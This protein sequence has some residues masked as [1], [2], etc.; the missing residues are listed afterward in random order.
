MLRRVVEDYLES[1]KEIQ[2]F[3]PFSSLLLL[4]GYHDIHIIHSSVEFGKD[5]IA[6]KEEDG[7]V[8]Q[9][10]YQLKAGDINLPK[11]REEIQPQLL[12]AIVNNL[13]HPNYDST[14]PKKVFFVTTGTVR[15]PA[16]LAFQEFNAFIGQKFK[17]DPVHSIEKLELVEDFV[18]FGLEPFFVLHNDPTFI[19]DFFDL[20]S[21]I[22]N[23][24]ALD[25]FTIEAYTKRWLNIDFN[26]DINRLQVFLEAYLFS[27]LLYKSKR[28]YESI[29]FIAA[30]VRCLSKNNLYTQHHKVIEEFIS[31]TATI[32]IEDVQALYKGDQTL[33]NPASTTGILAIFKYPKFCLH[34]L[35]ILSLFNLLSE[36]VEPELTSFIKEIIEKERGWERPLSDN[37]AV[38]IALIGLSLIKSSEK[39]IF[40]KLINNV[41]IWFC[42]RHSKI[43][44][45]P[46]GASEEEESEQLLSEFLDGLTHNK[47]RSSFLACVLLDLAYLSDDSVFYESI[48][49]ELRASSVIIERFH[50]LNDSDIYD[51]ENISNSYDSE[52]SKKYTAIYSGGILMDIEN[53]KISI[54]SNVLFFLAF[55]LRD[56]VF[57][58]FIREIM[59]VNPCDA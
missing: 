44:L 32:I 36:K 4:K 39:D 47:M 7:V 57:P 12:E 11:F 1:I 34:A 14:L 22:R 29:L 49:N 8:V 46:L 20:Y 40:K 9:Y 33:A 26:N 6:K 13:A 59:T 3:L 15:P 27:S 5:I 28:Y 2:F 54:R 17:L 53:S 52:Y 55:L 51:Y 18:K 41:T 50:I 30:L 56:R 10:V 42:D 37:Y 38:S 16:T 43:G 48:A 19:G 21:K 31:E 45:A 25:S 35:E 24:R 58:T 23:D